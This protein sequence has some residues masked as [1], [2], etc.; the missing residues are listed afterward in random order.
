MNKHYF[1]YLEHP[2]KPMYAGKYRIAEYNRCEFTLYYIVLVSH[3]NHY[4]RLGD[5]STRTQVTFF[6][7]WGLSVG[8]VH[9]KPVDG[10]RSKGIL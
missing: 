4:Q 3:W 1:L 9:K 6:N 8:F 2:L 5:R 10:I 7:G